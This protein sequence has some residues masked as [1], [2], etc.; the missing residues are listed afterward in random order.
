MISKATMTIAIVAILAGL[1]AAYGVR[2]LLTAPKE[3]PEQPVAARPAPRII[4]PLASEDLPADRL[5][6]A[7]DIA[8]VEMTEKQ[9]EERFKGLDRMVLIKLDRSII[10]RRLRQPLRQGQP[11]LT[12]ALYL[13]GTGPS[14]TDRLQSG[15]RAVSLQVSD[16]HGGIVQPGTHVDVVFRAQP[17]PAGR[18]GELAIPEVTT[19]LLSHIEV[20]EV[21]RA[22][23][24]G[25]GVDAKTALVTLAV[26]AEKADVLGA[27]EGRGELWLVARS[28]K[29]LDRM[30]EA[31]GSKLTL[32]GLLGIQPPPPPETPVQTAVFRRG[33]MQINTFVAG[34]LVSQSGSWLPGSAGSCPG[35]GKGDTAPLTPVPEPGPPAATPGPPTPAPREPKGPTTR[36]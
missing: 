14:L 1:V 2:A 27:V 30:A 31:S 5:L 21:A 11:F 33:H 7:G 19:T 36:S 24:P 20:L 35:C 29:E 26:P 28:P 9:F 8:L 16:T 3:K 34:R 13:E 32:E 4:M 22:P 15:F 23:A 18:S 12:T 10:G 6:V 17:R 25:G